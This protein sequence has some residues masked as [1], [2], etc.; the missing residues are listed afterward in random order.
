VDV[1]A[2]LTQVWL[3][4]RCGQWQQIGKNFSWKIAHIS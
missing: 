4:I 3:L 1:I 2:D